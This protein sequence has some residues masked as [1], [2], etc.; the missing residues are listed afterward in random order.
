M[1]VN[2]S[3]L[4]L[5]ALAAAVSGCNAV[6][7]QMA[8]RDRQRRECAAAGGYFEENKIGAPDNYTCKGLAGSPAAPTPPPPAN[9]RTDTKTVNQADGTVVTN[10]NQVCTSF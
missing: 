1:I 7:E 5:L 2:R 6:N 4:A 10:S 3:I 8:Y 9:C